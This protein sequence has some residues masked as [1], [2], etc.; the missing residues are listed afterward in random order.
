MKLLG[1]IC[2]ATAASALLLTTVPATAPVA[3]AGVQW[4]SAVGAILGDIIN[5]STGHSSKS[6]NSDGGLLGGLSNQKHARQNPN[7]NEKLFML[8][9]ENSDY[10]T[11]RAMI[12]A[13]VDVNGVFPYHQFYYYSGHGRTAFGVALKKNDLDMM[14]LLLEN[15]ADVTGF[16]T[17]ENKHYSYVDVAADQYID[18]NSYG[19]TTDFSTIQY[20]LNWG[21]NINEYSEAMGKSI[22][23][24]PLDNCIRNYNSSKTKALAKFLLELGAYTESRYNNGDTPFLAAIRRNQTELARILADGGADISA[25]D[26]D[27]KNA[28]QIALEKNNLQLYKEV[29]DIMS[30]GQQPSKYQE[31]KDKTQK[32][33]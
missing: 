14:Q 29:Q 2:A 4:G 28:L 19:Y 33:T 5:K 12:A 3:H 6:G 18:S 21:A 20:L 31:I 13:G 8:A 24:Y 7:D 22:K 15:G 9:V 32:K 17:Y 23:R 26:H 11:V 25:K 1:K 16:Y 30:R 10:D 27:G